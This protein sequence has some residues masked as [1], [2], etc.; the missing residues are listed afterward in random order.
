MIGF[1]ARSRWSMA[2]RCARM[3]ALALRGTPADDEPDEIMQGYFRRGKQLQAD[4]V[5][6]LTQ[7][8][9]AE[10]LILEKPIPWPAGIAHGDIFITTRGRAIEVK[11]AADPRPVDYHLTQ[12]AGQIHFDEDAVDGALCVVNPSNLERHWYP[13]PALTDE[14][15]ERV[16]SIAAA[17]ARTA[18]PA[19]PLPERCCSKPS[20]ARSRMCPFVGPCFADWTPPDPIEIEGDVAVLAARHAEL[21]DEVK[22]AKETL[23]DAEERRREVRAALARTIEPAREYLARDDA[24]IVRRTSVAGRVTWNVPLAIQMGVIDASVLEPFRR[25]GNGHDRWTVKA[26]HLDDDAPQDSTRTLAGLLD[27][28]EDAPF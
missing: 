17:V 11:S 14:M 3:G 16:E 6:S 27:F 19:A 25:E 13:M 9:G 22:A 12:L 23:V 10:N 20:D 1:E 7:E 5:E 2:S 24:L 18:D 15:V 8:Y 28:G 21:D 26:A 4:V